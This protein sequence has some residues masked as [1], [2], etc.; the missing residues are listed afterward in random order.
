MRRRMQRVASAL[1]FSACLAGMHADA[2]SARA[3]YSS[4][5]LYNLANAY[6]RDGKP[7]MAVVN[8]ERARLLAPD[9]PDIEANLLLV[10]RSLGLP[11]ETRS[12]LDRVAEAASPTVAAW[13][14]VIGLMLAAV[15]LLAGR[16]QASHRWARRISIIVGIALI[17]VPVGDGVMLWPRLHEGIVI[18][19]TAPV[20]VSPAPMGDTLFALKEAEAVK[21]AGEYEG[22]VLVRTA[23]GRTGWVWHADLAPVV[24]RSW[25]GG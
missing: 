20:R 21:I 11:I 2:Q 5:A 6:A 16:L 22:F 4:T 9:D 17:G 7:G 25:T 15:A 23:T 1:I 14:G 12:R 18:A 3:G 10:R 8:Y 24:P 19:G 13:I